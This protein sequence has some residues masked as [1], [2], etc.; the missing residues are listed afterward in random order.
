MDVQIN[1]VL[2]NTDS[3]CNTRIQSFTEY[4]EAYK[5]MEI[6]YRRTLSA[7]EMDEDET[8]D[9]TYIE[10]NSAQIYDRYG[11]TISWIIEKAFVQTPEIAAICWQ[12]HE[13]TTEAVK[14]ASY[15]NMRESSRFCCPCADGYVK[16]YYRGDTEILFFGID[17]MMF[18]KHKQFIPFEAYKWCVEQGVKTI[19]NVDE[20]NRIIAEI[21]ATALFSK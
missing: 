4:E 14:G 7:S 19:S 21:D 16:A 2:V 17:F 10:K 5:T 6:E 1:H 20:A 8:D 12:Y 18:D 13:M 9:D 3:D 15:S 11:D